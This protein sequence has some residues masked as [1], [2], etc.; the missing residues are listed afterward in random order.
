MR[1]ILLALLIFSSMSFGQNYNSPFPRTAYF[2][3]AQGIGG[4][5]N[6]IKLVQ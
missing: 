2:S 1:N 3:P 5:P 4:A 6:G